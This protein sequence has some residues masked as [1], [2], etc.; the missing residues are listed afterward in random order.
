MT[1]PIYDASGK[2]LYTLQQMKDVWNA[3]AAYYLSISK[4]DAPCWTD[5]IATVKPVAPTIDPVELL[6][7]IVDGDT[8]FDNIIESWRD[9]IISSEVLINTYIGWKS[10]QKV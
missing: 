10:Q 1:K 3:A 4:F 7:W 2:G 6:D 5:Y 8:K 9:S